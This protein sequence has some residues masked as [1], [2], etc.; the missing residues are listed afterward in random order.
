ML[1]EGRASNWALTKLEIE[2]LGIEVP[3]QINGMRL[4]VLREGMTCDGW[5]RF[6]IVSSSSS[7][8][9]E[10]STGLFHLGRPVCR[11]KPRLQDRSAQGSGLVLP[12]CR[13]IVIPPG[14][15]TRQMKNASRSLFPADERDNRGEV[16]SRSSTSWTSSP[17]L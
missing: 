9:I 6:I 12:R 3:F 1:F 7:R 16:H 10:S 8:T 2:N 15:Q 5:V 4:M 13:C 14:P 17:S 11:L